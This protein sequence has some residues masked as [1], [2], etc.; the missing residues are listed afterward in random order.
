MKKSI[1]VALAFALLLLSLLSGCARQY[2]APETTDL[3]FWITE[4]VAQVDFENYAS[5]PGFGVV[6]YYGRGYDA[7]AK[8]YVCYDIT[9]YPDYSDGGSYVTRIGITDPNVKVWNDLTITA[10]VEEW[11]HLLNAQGYTRA[12]LPANSDPAIRAM[13]KSS[14]G[15]VTIRLAQ[16]ES[17]SSMAFDV[18]VTN[19]YGIQY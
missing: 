2:P 4:D 7:E 9:A 13:W 8:E 18:E 1:F 11:E 5:Q 3:E 12:E 10:S 16:N 15:K 19:R 17:G 6:R 14:D